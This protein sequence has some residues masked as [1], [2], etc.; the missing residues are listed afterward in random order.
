MLSSKRSEG[1]ISSFG[2]VGEPVVSVGDVSLDTVHDT[3]DDGW[4]LYVWIADDQLFVDSLGED[5]G[6][7]V[8]T[9]ESPD[10]FVP[11]MH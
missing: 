6:D 5:E 11:A 9:G 4:G 3:R 7:I 10:R 2:L 1:G 8:P